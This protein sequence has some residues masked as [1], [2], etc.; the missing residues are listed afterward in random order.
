MNMKKTFAIL[1]LAALLSLVSCQKNDTPPSE[2]SPQTTETGAPTVTDSET[3][4]TYSPAESSIDETTTAES[5][6]TTENS[7][8]ELPFVPLN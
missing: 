4:E 5:K 6:E 2:S 1:L 8:V 3:A 7:P